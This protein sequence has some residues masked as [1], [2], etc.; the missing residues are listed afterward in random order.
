MRYC[1]ICNGHRAIKHLIYDIKYFWKHKVRGI[2]E[3]E[4]NPMEIMASLL[5]AVI[6]ASL[7]GQVSKDIQDAIKD[8]EEDK[9]KR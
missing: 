5:P 3:P 6:M 8:S 1:P 9:L 2:P 4:I 7:V